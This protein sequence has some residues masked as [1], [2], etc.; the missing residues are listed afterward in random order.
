[1]ATN[2][3]LIAA[4]CAEFAG[5]IR[6]DPCPPEKRIG[7]ARQSFVLEA[8]EVGL[9]YRQRSLKLREQGFGPRVIATSP[10]SAGSWLR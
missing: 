9:Q 5:S 7:P 4:V 10:P 8:R 3:Y 6:R 2:R 1:L